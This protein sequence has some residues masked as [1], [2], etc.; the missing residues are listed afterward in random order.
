MKST[1]FEDSAGV[2]MGITVDEQPS[3]ETG[4]PGE[5]PSILVNVWSEEALPGDQ[6]RA[7]VK[8]KGLEDED[9][10]DLGVGVIIG[11]GANDDTCD[12]A[13]ITFD[14]YEND[15]PDGDPMYST[16]QFGT[17]EKNRLS[18]R[19]LPPRRIYI[20]ED[21][22]VDKSLVSVFED[23]YPRQKA[24]SR[25]NYERDK[26]V[27]AAQTCIAMSIPIDELIFRQCVALT[28][29]IVRLDRVE[30]NA[31]PAYLKNP[32]FNEYLKSN[33]QALRIGCEYIL[34]GLRGRSIRH[35]DDP[36]G[37]DEFNLTIYRMVLSAWYKNIG[38]LVRVFQLSIIVYETDAFTDGRKRGFFITQRTAACLDLLCVLWYCLETYFL[39]RCRKERWDKKKTQFRMIMTS[40]GLVDSLIGVFTD[41]PYRVTRLLRVYYYSTGSVRITDVFAI[42]YH[43]LM[44]SARIM[45][46]LIFFVIFCACV[47]FVMWLHKLPKV[48]E[49]L[50]SDP[51]AQGEGIITPYYDTF[52]NAIY[53]LLVCLSTANFPDIMLEPLDISQWY[54][55]FFIMLYIMGMVFL[56][57]L[58]LGNILDG[59]QDGFEED[60]IR[61][62]E[63][64]D[65]GLKKAFQLLDIHDN[66]EPGNIT[67]ITW[68]KVMPIIRPDLE[69]QAGEKFDEID[70]DKSGTID[71]EEFLNLLKE[72]GISKTEVAAED[73]DEGG[74]N[75]DDMNFIRAW[76]MEHLL[77]KPIYLFG[78]KFFAFDFLMDL[79]VFTQFLLVMWATQ[80]SGDAEHRGVQPDWAYPVDVFFIAWYCVEVVVKVY[81]Y[82]WDVYFFEGKH[83]FDYIVTFL[84][85]CALI[86]PEEFSSQVVILR[87]LRLTRLISRIPAVRRIGNTL[88]KLSPHYGPLFMSLTLIMYFFSVI[89]M[90][91][92][93]GLL[94][95][96]KVCGA[97]WNDHM[98]LLGKCE[99]HAGL[100]V[101]EKLGDGCRITF[102]GKHV[103]AYPNGY[104][105]RLTTPRRPDGSW[106]G[107]IV[108]KYKN[109][110][111]TNFTLGIKM[112]N[113]WNA[114]KYNHKSHTTASDG[115][116]GDTDTACAV[117]TLSGNICKFSVGTTQNE[118]LS[119]Y[120]TAESF[121]MRYKYGL[122]EDQDMMLWQGI[123]KTKYGAIYD[124]GL[125]DPL[126]KYGNRVCK[127][128]P[129]F[130][131]Y[132]PGLGREDGWKFL[133]PHLTTLAD[134][135]LEKRVYMDKLEDGC[136]CEV[137]G[138]TT[139]LYSGNRILR[140]F[141]ES[142]YILSGYEFY[143]NFDDFFGAMRVCTMLVIVNNWHLMVD[144][145]TIATGTPFYTRGYFILFY[146]LTVVY[147]FNIIVSFTLAAFGGVS[148]DDEDVD[149]AIS[150]VQDKTRLG[151]LIKYSHVKFDA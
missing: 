143:M 110:Q 22:E 53:N 85:L 140:L 126:C 79:I 91:A 112:H 43:K 115:V 108:G 48:L 64:V 45:L 90:I 9:M 118:R 148:D 77:E 46:M 41:T 72:I 93:S 19:K 151:H 121:K 76:I 139:Y 84:G 119:H 150:I 127:K 27:E 8:E 63:R 138:G 12:V 30:K 81:G 117:G 67:K 60:V 107:P 137:Q 94:T 104:P 17:F 124:T 28:R 31:D 70:K 24:L 10:G 86:W 101:N 132:N 105:V 29:E 147:F 6:R 18:L 33:D 36:Q 145:C 103:D 78:I 111:P 89:G 88:F 125:L 99:S 11:P 54:Y 37:R 149:T 100:W 106:Y 58:V 39:V 52:S 80:L 95:R 40:I 96:E 23:L 1:S 114:G 129:P 47:A 102:P 83:L 128:P 97:N 122:H 66:E 123:I 65:E 61:K 50:G 35:L 49:R 3:I 2:E 20:D 62:L 71:L 136:E 34:D 141:C 113:I 26:T 55:F 16:L 13:F 133:K 142:A 74:L 7:I 144:A 69:D 44:S 32:D 25:L 42:A 82:G 56:Q 4:E 109:F 130:Y 51:L 120:K 15:C 73:D 134:G 116:I 57:N 5:H 21:G 146:F 68:M 135:K 14:N 98:S 38:F 92:F 59:I 131:A 87:L 75:A